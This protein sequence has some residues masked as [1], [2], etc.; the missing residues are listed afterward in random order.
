MKA[1]RS[2]REPFEIALLSAIVLYGVLATIFF[3]QVSVTTL[4]SFPAP[5]GRLFIAA[6]GAGAAVALL[7]AVQ[8][9][10]TGILIEKMGLWSVAGLGSA[11]AIWSIGVNGVKALAFAV[12]ILGVAAASAARLRQIYM[13]NRAST[14]AA[15]IVTD[16]RIE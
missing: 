9:T 5:W 1:I 12:L 6:F 2:G 15:G 14:T 4:R 11:F 13:A 7:G 16:E 10:I 3:D 8:P